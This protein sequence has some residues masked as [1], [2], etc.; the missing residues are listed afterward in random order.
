[1]THK[2]NMEAVFDLV[3]EAYAAILEHEEDSNLARMK[4]E[5]ILLKH[6]YKHLT[7]IK[8]DYENAVVEFTTLSKDNPL[9]SMS[10]VITRAKELPDGNTEICSELVLL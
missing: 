1:M 5:L 10:K 6:I 9:F 4:F 7:I 3:N 2:E 8:W